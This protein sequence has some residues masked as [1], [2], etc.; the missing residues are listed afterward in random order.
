MAVNGVEIKVGQVWT[1]K[2]G[3]E[4]E[5]RGEVFG[6]HA[7]QWI[8]RVAGE[9]HQYSQAGTYHIDAPSGFDLDYLVKDVPNASAEDLASGKRDDDNGWFAHVPLSTAQPENTICERVEIKVRSGKTYQVEAEMVAWQNVEK[10]RL[11]HVTKPL[12]WEAVQQVSVMGN[13]AEMRE[14]LERLPP[15]GP[16]KPLDV[17]VGGDHYK[18][19]AIQPVEYIH[20]NQIGYCEGS[21]IKYVTRWRSKGGVADLEKAKHFLELLISLEAK[22]DG[23]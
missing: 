4:A 7:A 11:I 3:R 21:V 6:G 16:I 23:A 15:T 18:S 9:D 19:L 2:G 10:Y 5:V 13:A 17:Q 14:Q 20:A 8:V 1:T 22:K 12:K